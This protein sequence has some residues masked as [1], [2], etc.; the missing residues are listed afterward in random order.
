MMM[1]AT[2][3][4]FRLFTCSPEGSP[5]GRRR[6]G[7]GRR[8]ERSGERGTAATLWSVADEASRESSSV[9]GGDLLSD[10]AYAR[11]AV[12]GREL[13]RENVI[14]WIQSLNPG[15]GAAWLSAFDDVSL[16]AYLERLVRQTEP[17]GGDSRWSRPAGEP[18]ITWS[19]SA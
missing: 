9:A 5:L 16:V 1:P 4:S 6:H 10:E 19:E 11:L 3:R 12:L 17:R 7:T 13:T 14:A 2:N 15:V 18:A 8:R